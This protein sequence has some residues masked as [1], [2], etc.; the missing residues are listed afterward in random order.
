MANE[1][2]SPLHQARV[3]H[4]IIQAISVTVWLIS[5]RL[6]GVTKKSLYRKIVFRRCVAVSMKCGLFLLH[7]IFKLND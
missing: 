1:N 2:F 5:S 7:A 3:E 4:V 6:G